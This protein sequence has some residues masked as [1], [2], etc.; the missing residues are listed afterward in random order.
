MFFRNLLKFTLVPIN[1]KTFYGRKAPAPVWQATISCSAKVEWPHIC[2]HTQ[3]KH[4]AEGGG[5]N[6]GTGESL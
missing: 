4:W 6:R 5:A 2:T 3:I 1:S